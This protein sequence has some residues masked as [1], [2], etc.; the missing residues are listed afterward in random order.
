LPPELPV[1]DP[2]LAKPHLRRAPEAIPGRSRWSGSRNNRLPGC[3]KSTFISAMKRLIRSL[4]LGLALVTLMSAAASA[5]DFEGKVTLLKTTGTT[6]TTEVQYFKS[7]MMRMESTAPAAAEDAKD[8]KDA[9]STAKSKRKV[10]SDDDATGTGSGAMIMRPAEKQMIILMPAQKAY[11][12]Q[13]LDL[14]KTAKDLKVDDVSFERTGKTE[15]IAGYDCV[16]YLTKSSYGATEIWAVEG[17][18]GFVGGG[19]GNR[20]ASKSESGWM[21]IVREKGLFPLRTV[22]FNAKGKETM[23]LEAT[24]VEKQRLSDDL[25]KPPAD[26][27]EF[28]IPGM[29]GGLGDLLKGR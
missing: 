13:T 1:G 9:K 24:S 14:E 7:G 18:S 6:V 28:K 21:T 19:G 25:F 2:P 3:S 5:K 26:Y 16:Q 11:M 23:R 29:P 17:L 10:R 8:V 4:G 27:T 12:I 20:G 15:T 22:V